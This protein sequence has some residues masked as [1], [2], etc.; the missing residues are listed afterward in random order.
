MGLEKHRVKHHM[1]ASGRLRQGGNIFDTLGAT[2]MTV[3]RAAQVAGK[4]NK[5]KKDRAAS[6]PTFARG[7]FFNQGGSK[8]PTADELSWFLRG[9]LREQYP[10]R[11]MTRFQLFVK[12]SRDEHAKDPR[13]PVHEILNTIPYWAVSQPAE[14]L[15]QRSKNRAASTWYEGRNMPG[16][17]AHW[18]AALYGGTVRSAKTTDASKDGATATFKAMGPATMKSFI[19]IAHKEVQLFLDEQEGQPKLEDMWKSLPADFEIRHENRGLTD[20]RQ[21]H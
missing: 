20:G 2:G 3:H 18:C 14:L 16:L 8:A 4:G 21:G 1:A 17:L 12:T 11:L 6:S 10:E 9:L 13:V 7:T 5:L 15:W 19:A